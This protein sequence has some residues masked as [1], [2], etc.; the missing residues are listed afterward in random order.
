MY[1]LVVVSHGN[2]AEQ[3]V[4]TSEMIL[5]KQDGLESLCLQPGE[6]KEDFENRLEKKLNKYKGREILVLAD[7]YGGTPFNSTMTHVLK[8]G[9]NISLLTGV[10]LPMIIQALLSKEEKICE[11]IEEIKNA[12]VQGIQ[13]GISALCS[14]D[15]E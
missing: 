14:S 2:L 6:C 10:N 7:L 15:D 3:M 13:N 9:H 8:G 11:V 4:K 12:A 1:S 5:G